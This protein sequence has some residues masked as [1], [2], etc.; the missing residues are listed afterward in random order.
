MPAH[1]DGAG[2]AKL[3]TL[4]DAL[5]LLQRLHAIVERMAS[6]ARAQ[7][8]TSLHKQQVQRAAAPLVGLLKPQFDLLAEK[9]SEMLLITSRGGGDQVKVRAFRE[10]VAQL[11]TQIEVTMGRV[12]ELHTVDAD[13]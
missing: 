6:S 13:K 1:I 8:D 10:A 3:Q 12:R 7:Q 11:R 4:E 5:T 2:L 9:V